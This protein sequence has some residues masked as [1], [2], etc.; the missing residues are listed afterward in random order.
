MLGAI[1]HHSSTLF[2]SRFP[3]Q[4]QTVP[5]WLVLLARLFQG[6]PIITF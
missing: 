1:L 4:A 3:G 2:L 5:I 6:L